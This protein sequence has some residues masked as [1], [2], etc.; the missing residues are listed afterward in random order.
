MSRHRNVRSSNIEEFS[1]A[2][3]N[4]IHEITKRNGTFYFL[5][6]INSDQNISKRSIGRSLYLENLTSC[7]CLTIITIPSSVTK[8]SSTSIDHTITN[9]Y[10]NIINPGVILCENELSDH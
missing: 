5:R 4:T 1:E 7:S 3:C 10:A 9:D 6:D 2:L 8:N